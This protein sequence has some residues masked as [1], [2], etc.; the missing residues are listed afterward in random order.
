MSLRI[1]SSRH[2]TI[3]EAHSI[4]TSLTIDLSHPLS[5]YFVQLSTP[6][7]SL[8]KLP[9]QP[10]I[11]ITE[12]PSANITMTERNRP[13]TSHTIHLQ[14]THNHYYSRQPSTSSLLPKVNNEKQPSYQVTN[15]KMNLNKYT[16]ITTDNNGQNRIS[17]YIYLIT[18]A[19]PDHHFFLG[20]SDNNHNNR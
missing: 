9:R 20:N 17:P 7:I 13:H 14:P 12:P 10:S 8:G 2:H 1:I 3:R 4:D 18:P 19:S 11:I 15:C 5:Y 6:F 16:P